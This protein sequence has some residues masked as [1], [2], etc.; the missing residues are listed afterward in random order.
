MPALPAVPGIDPLAMTV[1]PMVSRVEYKLST[2]GHRFL[3]YVQREQV[4]D[5][6]WHATAAKASAALG[7]EIGKVAGQRAARYYA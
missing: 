1:V 5:T 4:V 2:H 3:A 7:R 6:G